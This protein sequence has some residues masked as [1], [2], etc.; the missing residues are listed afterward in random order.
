M[1]P[2]ENAMFM[3]RLLCGLK[4]SLG[5][6]IRSRRRPG[7][8]C[9][10]SARANRGHSRGLSVE[11]LEGRL[12]LTAYVVDTPLDDPSVGADVTDGFV[13]LREAIQAA[14]TNLPF[15]DAPAGD[16]GGIYNEGTLTVQNS[17]FTNNSVTNYGYGGA[18]CNYSTDSEFVP[19]TT[20]VNSLF[21]GN[22]AERGWG[23][24]I[25][26]ANKEN[27]ENSGTLTIIGST[28]SENSASSSG[29]AIYHWSANYPSYLP[30][31]SVSIL[32]STF[33]GNEAPIGGGVYLYNGLAKI[34][35]STFANNTADWWGGAICTFTRWTRVEID[36]STFSQNW[37][38]E[39]G[40]IDNNYAALK[41]SNSTLSGNS[42]DSVGGAIYNWG[43]ALQIANGTL[44]AN[45][46]DAD[47]N[48]S[49]NG[50]AIHDDGGG[51]TYLLDNTIVAGNRLGAPG[52]DSPN[53]FSATLD[54]ASSHNLIGDAATAGGLVH[55]VNG[56]LVGNAGSGTVDITT[57]F[58]PNL[59]DNGGATLTHA[60]V[61]GG[62][63]I[64][65]GDNTK[66]VDADGNPLVYDQRGDGFARIVDGTVDIGAL[67]VQPR[68]LSVEID[69]KPGSDPNSINLASQGVIAVAIFTTDDF[70]ASLVDASTVVFAGAGAVHSALEDVD[71]DGDLDLVLHF[72]VQ[73]TNLAQVY[74]GLLAE[75]LEDDV[76]DSNRQA[77]T[78]SLTGQTTADE[79]FAGFDEV[80]LFLSGKSLREFVRDLMAAGVI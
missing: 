61:P 57:V 32:S 47:G 71:G 74:A 49:G 25:A 56:N 3:N 66:A 45:R 27:Q 40:A 2:K 64:D 50:G 75:D 26:N 60:L 21:T 72:R 9:R 79:Y 67:E 15:G 22:T 76:L 53:E 46:A 37:A 42:T 10:L 36:N 28:F 52:N 7:H 35:S 8:G 13:S 77:A 34:G 54:P 58:D 41:I 29:G 55:G 68:I 4:N 19:S 5:R 24:A 39:G 33:D 70:D 65:A 48:G 63:A 62:P 30:P 78:I 73:D 1:F 14:N 38:G 43:G 18:I 51:A 69:I 44:T 17:T 23:G 59:A 31:G 6:R 20:V 16:G 11:A 12:L 80:D